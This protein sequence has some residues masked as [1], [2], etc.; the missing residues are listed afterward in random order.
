MGGIDGK[1]NNTQRLMF[2]WFTHIL[3]RKF[4]LGEVNMPLQP[5]PNFSSSLFVFFMFNSKEK[6]GCC[7][8]HNVTIS[9]FTEK[10]AAGNRKNVCRK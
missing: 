3:L 2:M 7:L 9:R 6:I 10:N 4:G 1:V 8:K 5:Y